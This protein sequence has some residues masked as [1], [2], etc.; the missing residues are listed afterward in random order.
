VS[1]I[2]FKEWLP[3]QP[4]FNN[5]GLIEASNVLPVG[6]DSSG[7]QPYLPLVT[8]SGAYT[9]S[10]TNNTVAIQVAQIGGSTP[11]VY[12]ATNDTHVYKSL[13]TGGGWTDIAAG[14]GMSTPATAL[15]QY[16]DIVLAAVPQ[17]LGIYQSSAGSSATLAP[18]AGSP[19]A[20]VLG[21]VGQFLMGGNLET[22]PKSSP[23]YVQWS[24]IANPTDWPVP[25]SDS[26][27]A[28]QAGQQALHFENGI[29]TGIFG[30]DQ[31]AVILQQSA[32]TRVTYIGG[33]A[34]FQFDTLSA[35]IGMDNQNCGVKVG[36]LI[37]FVSS[38]GVYATDGTS[39]LPIGEG[40]VSLWLINNI[41]SAGL[42]VTGRVAVDWTNK[43]IYWS[44]T[45]GV[46]TQLLIYN[47]ETQRFSHATESVLMWLVAAN[48][49]DFVNIP[50]QGISSD[51]KLGTLTGTPGTATFTTGEAELT[52][53]GY[54]RVSGVKPL[55][56]ATAGA[57]VCSVGYRNDLQ[58]S[59][60]FATD[61]TQNSRSGFADFRIE[62]RYQRA[63]VKVT[64]TFTNAQ[65]LEFNA[66]P[67]GGV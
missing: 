34:V 16:N 1:T 40:K 59:S 23:H 14:S 11:Y 65:G 67:G 49:A 54:T 57:M 58:S 47:F 20:A 45:N 31:W 27:L 2:L 42:L 48:V 44:F 56:G 21:I 7:F 30:G 12:A 60:T 39:L 17:G 41:V 33:A 37:Y 15:I 35:G 64:G 25:G 55:V 63:R 13:A 53:G 10:G 28:S 24:S 5:P 50:I 52:P 4:A 19:K 61:T 26:A 8:I 62:A 6:D 51:N 9:S 43:L 18:V 29:V 38:R 22:T 3:D 46:T 66:V 36:N 32:I